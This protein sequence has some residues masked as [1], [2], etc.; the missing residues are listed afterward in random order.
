MQFA[1]TLLFLLFS[2]T[3]ICPSS[4]VV[5]QS[6][7]D[8]LTSAGAAKFAA[9]VDGDPFLKGVF[10][11]PTTRTIFAPSDQALDDF[12]NK[13][14]DIPRRRFRIRATSPDDQAALSMSASDTQ[15][16]TNKQRNV[17]GT[18]FNT[19][20][21]ANTPSKK[22]VVVSNPTSNKKKSSKRD[23]PGPVPM[24]SGLSPIVSVHQA[25]ESVSVPHQ[26]SPQP[27][28]PESHPETV[29][30]PA[31]PPPPPE[32]HPIS[33]PPHIES[34]FIS[35][36][37]HVETTPCP[38]SS[39]TPPPPPPP[40]VTTV[41]PPPPEPT[42]TLLPIQV[43]SG[44]GRS[45]NIIKQDVPFDGGF[46]HVIDGVFTLPQLLSKTATLTNNTDF[47]SA[48][49]SSNLTNALDNATGITAFIPNN[50]AVAASGGALSANMVN[51]HIIKGFVGY[52]P[53]LVVG[54]TLTTAAGHGVQ[55]TV[56][57]EDYFVG[58]AKILDSNLILDNGVAHV[59]ETV[60]PEPTVPFEGAGPVTGPGGRLGAIVASFVAL[61]LSL[62]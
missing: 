25:P 24:L 15:T 35:Y 45:V 44:L 36:P 18:K 1:V 11:D 23:F 21:S 61:L 38:P 48:M 50:A 6:F 13:T 56:V 60:I 20:K 3:S 17:P 49:Q 8:A 10:L 55:I 32:S 40:E 34:H 57:G 52:L 27:P 22:A 62:F 31:P 2:L 5:A 46:I 33:Y 16:D 39:T 54:S 59:I 51:N 41:A 42:E 19:K 12:F 43:F 14:Q 7:L 47:A 30:Y 4:A 29:S 28:P 37:P 58:G 53:D 9:I 26:P